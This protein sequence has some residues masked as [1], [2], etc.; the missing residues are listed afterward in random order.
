[1]HKHEFII[2]LST[3]AISYI[4]C[5]VLRTCSMRIKLV[6]MVRDDRW[7]KA[8]CVPK[9]GGICI[10]LGMI[11]WLSLLHVITLTLFLLVGLIDDWKPLTPVQKSILLAP[12]CV[13]TSFATGKWYIGFI[14]W[15]ITNALNVL[16]HADGIAGTTAMIVCLFAMNSIGFAVVGGCAGFLILNFP[17]AKIYLGDNGSMLLGACMVL[18][19]QDY[20]AV[21]M[22]L[23]S[24]I[25]LLELGF[26]TIRR[27]ASRRKPWIGGTDHT[28]HMMLRNGIEPRVV[29]FVYGGMAAA[30]CFFARWS[31]H[32]R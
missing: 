14:Y 1:M 30:I 10:F 32:L 24:I 9:P 16:D 20:G 22:I 3:A 4:A 5:M 17:P 15:F 2:I 12:A 13:F 27:L 23:A 31:S 21:S 19:W 11:P 18:C 7:S 8:D 26:V 28:G 25:P 6:S 29:P